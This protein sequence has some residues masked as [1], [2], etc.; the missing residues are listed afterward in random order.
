MNPGQFV[1]RRRYRRYIVSGT[2]RF[3]TNLEAGSGD[4]VNLGDGGILIRSGV[5]LPEGTEGSFHVVPSHCPFEFEIQGR[6]VGVKGDRMAIR[7][8]QRNQTV[9]ALI[10]W[11]EREN[12]PWTGTV[13]MDALSAVY[14]LRMESC[15][16]PAQAED[17]ELECARE[18]VFRTA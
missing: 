3:V 2:V 5:A 13:A 6:V 9:A 4:L 15:A 14:S 8:L 11:L 12:F 18:L 17:A 16:L 7:F 1:E 10:Q